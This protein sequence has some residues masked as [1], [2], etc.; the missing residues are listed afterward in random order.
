[1]THSRQAQLLGMGSTQRSDIPRPSA[2]PLHVQQP[3]GLLLL[4]PGPR[5]PA[6]RANQNPSV[7]AFAQ[8]SPTGGLALMQ[9]HDMQRQQSAPE[10]ERAPAREPLSKNEE[11]LALLEEWKKEPDELGAEWWAKF[12]EELKANRLNF[13][14]RELP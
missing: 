14:E 1:M 6:R 7:S 13:P 9:Y 10:S 12:D 5:M 3:E 11:I 2:P 4:Q 8:T